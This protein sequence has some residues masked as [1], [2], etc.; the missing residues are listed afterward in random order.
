MSNV[1]V[2]F[3]ALFSLSGK[4]IFNLTIGSKML[5]ELQ[6]IRVK[7]RKPNEENICLVIN[8]RFY[9]VYNK[10]GVIKIGNQTRVKAQ[11][12]SKVFE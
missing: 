2:L 10:H 11:V 1:R 9:I 4:N 5:R 7:K 12:L 3:P 6:I 8:F